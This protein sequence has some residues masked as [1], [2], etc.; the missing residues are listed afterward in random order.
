M[1]SSKTFSV[2]CYFQVSLLQV[3]KIVQ[4]C[5]L[6]CQI[7]V[8]TC[9]FPILNLKF[10]FFNN[11]PQ[12]LS[13]QQ[14]RFWLLSH[15]LAKIQS[16]LLAKL[17]QLCLQI[18]SNELDTFSKTNFFWFW[19]LSKLWSCLLYI[20]EEQNPNVSLKCICKVPDTVYQPY[21]MY[22]PRG[23]RRLKPLPV[24]SPHRQSRTMSTPSGEILR[25]R[26]DYHYCLVHH[27]N[28]GCIQINT[29]I[30]YQPSTVLVC[31]KTVLILVKSSATPTFNTT[32]HDV[33]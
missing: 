29:D 9:A 30:R 26:R 19:F 4:W 18:S 31:R 13:L 14:S 21:R 17:L 15:S 1:S 8:N 33:M 20:L 16:L 6:R 12:P 10:T 22:V 25:K 32:S 5:I 3:T 28:E 27:F 2:Q 24:F 7:L 11:F 23:F